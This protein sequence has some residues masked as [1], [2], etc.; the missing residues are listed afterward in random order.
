MPFARRAILSSLDPRFNPS[1]SHRRAIG[2][3]FMAIT[4]G[5]SGGPCLGESGD[6]FRSL[7]PLYFHDA[8][9]ALVD[10]SGL[11]FAIEEE[12][13]SRAKHTN[14][15]PARALSASLHSQSLDPGRVDR[16]GFFFDERFF[17]ADLARELRKTDPFV[18]ATC[19][20]RAILADRLSTCL[21]FEC[22]PSKL[23][24]FRHHDTHCR[25]T[26]Y[27]SRLADALSIVID[28]N[29]EWESIS[30][31]EVA[32]FKARVLRRY[33]IDRSLGH[34]YRTATS[35]LGF[36]QFDEYKVMGLAPYGQHQ[37]LG[38]AFAGVYC[39]LDHG[40]F[41]LRTPRLVEIAASLDLTADVG[42]RARGAYPSQ[43]AMDFAAAVQNVLES[44]VRD[45]VDYWTRETGLRVLCLSGGVAQN[46][47]M[48]G[49]LA[50]SGLVKEFYVN[51]ASH[52]AG[53]AIG[54]GLMAQDEVSGEGPCARAVF[55]PCIGTD[56][57]L[58]GACSTALAPWKELLQW[59]EPADISRE[60]AAQIANGKILGW[61][62]G[63]S[64]FGP[65]AL[66]HRSILA[67]P[68][69][70]ENWSRINRIIKRREDF[71]PFAPVV[72]RE[73]FEK[74]FEPPSACSCNLECMNFVV[75]V[76]AEFRELLGATTHVDGSARIQVVDANAM[77]DFHALL[78]SFAKLTGLPALLNTSFNA[79]DEPIVDSAHDAIHT[80]LSSGLDALV[81]GQWIV[82]RK[83][84]GAL[85]P[86]AMITIRPATGVELTSLQPG[87]CVAVRGPNTAA[88]P[89]WL[90]E[91]AVA[92]EKISLAALLKGHESDGCASTLSMVEDLW[93]RRFIDLVP[94]AA[95]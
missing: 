70:R 18:P 14:R 2:V 35:L 55:V 29:G 72:M 1:G 41:E 23:S 69:P 37:R 20:V 63:R 46:C 17:A 26:V 74:L 87:A 68:R 22:D 6:R 58:N 48:N 9:A 77:P 52:D 15:F 89:T 8:A 62:R 84:I 11:C 30:V 12:R 25:A 51:P 42:G 39:P 33:A 49:K 66:G 64:E 91:A 83:Y 75:N 50:T 31:Y 27:A 43:L 38:K 65:R 34:F 3:G 80:F 71:R 53:A 13:L 28:G 82:S 44:V 56:V 45:L 47:A 78:A 40:D 21:Q 76:R 5:I 90:A 10:P 85:P 54:A 79:S 93:R 24:F 73:A 88:L 95:P 7:H 61:A 94:I 32:H 59:D 4:I 81:L 57:D 36:G 67:D 92:N 60:A 86:E 16:F 19:D